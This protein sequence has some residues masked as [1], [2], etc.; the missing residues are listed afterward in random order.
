MPASSYPRPNHAAAPRMTANATAVAS[1]ALVPRTANAPTASAALHAER[2]PITTASLAKPERITTTL[3]AAAT[4]HME[5]NGMA[6]ARRDAGACR[7]AAGEPPQPE[8]A[9][10]AE[11]DTMAAAKKRHSALECPGGAITESDTKAAPTEA[12]RR[13]R[14][15]PAGG[16][17][18]PNA[19]AAAAAMAT[20]SQS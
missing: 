7:G 16:R 19:M 18:N 12:P 17:R 13:H 14:H 15:D 3:P 8:A 1:P 4:A 6:A 20:G 2:A 5:R 11:A 9:P 10:N